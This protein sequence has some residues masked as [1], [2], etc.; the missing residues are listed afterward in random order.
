MGN[1]RSIFCGGFLLLGVVFLG[2]GAVRTHKVYEEDSDFGV[3]VFNR[4]SE[5][6]LVEMST[7]SGAYVHNGRMVR[8]EWAMQQDGKQ[9][10]PT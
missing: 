3:V 2:V 1:V 7:Y 8:H 6:D 4:V 5:A 9:K 10:C